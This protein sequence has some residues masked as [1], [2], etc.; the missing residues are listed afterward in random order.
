MHSPHRVPIKRLHGNSSLAIKVLGVEG[1]CVGTTSCG[2]NRHRLITRDVEGSIRLSLKLRL[3]VRGE[4]GPCVME[5]KWWRPQD[6]NISS[7]R[8]MC[9]LTWILDCLDGT[10]A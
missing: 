1:L 3:R 2:E 6:G 8:I 4:L 9:E 7:G 10:T 5:F